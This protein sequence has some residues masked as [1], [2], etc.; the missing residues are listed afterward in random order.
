MIATILGATAGGFATMAAL[1]YAGLRRKGLDRW[2]LEYIRTRHLRRDYV[3]GEPLEVL[4]LVCDHYEPKRGGVSMT[5]ARSR[6][7]EWVDKYPKLF[8]EFR[9]SYGNPPQHTFFY[10]EDEYE[11]ELVDMV[12]GLC[13]KGYGDVEIHLH[14][15]NDTADGLR[16]KLVNFKTALYANHGLLRKDENGEITYGFI[17]G[18]WCLDNSRRDGRFCGVNNELDVLIETGCYADFTMPSAPSETQTR[19]INSVYWAVDDPAKPKSHDRG[20]LV[21]TA[22]R[23]PKSLLMVQG[24]LVLDWSKRRLGIFPTIENGNIQKN[25][26]PTEKRVGHWLRACVKIPNMANTVCVK[27]HTHGVWEPNQEVLLGQAMVSLHHHLRVQMK[28][29]EDF[30]LQYLTAHEMVRRC[31]F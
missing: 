14:H 15:D 19:T 31:R 6:V 3:P 26:P 18:N 13:R 24:P 9:D 5:K 28:E 27:L 30:T 11:P 4:L 16:E 17:H 23:P 29:H 25:Q 8:D 20:V 7:Q 2:L 12:A 22:P 21:G 1:G 10:P